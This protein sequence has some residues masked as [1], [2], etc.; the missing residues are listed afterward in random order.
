MVRETSLWRKQ[1][2]DRDEAWA[3][4]RTPPDGWTGTTEASPRY[5]LAIA[6][7]ST[8]KLSPQ[9]QAPV[10]LGLWTTNAAFRPSRA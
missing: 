1:A 7:L 6:C 9:P 10:A 4:C 8:V 5:R 3:R 2:G